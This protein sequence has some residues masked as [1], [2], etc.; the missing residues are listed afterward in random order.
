MSSSP[1]SI[2]ALPACRY[3][4]L[5]RYPAP[6]AGCSCSQLLAL[7]GCRR[8][9]PA[10]CSRSRVAGYP[11][12]AAAICDAAAAPARCRCGPAVAPCAGPLE[13]PAGLGS[14]HN[15][16]KLPMEIGDFTRHQLDKRL[17]LHVGSWPAAG[18]VG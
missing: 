15:A 11:A 17:G 12:A 2:T 8:A 6:A 3:G 16:G 14:C 18:L 5:P 9:A 4:L 1:L 10:S 13:A 7:A